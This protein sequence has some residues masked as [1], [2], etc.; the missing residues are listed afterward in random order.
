MT[1]TDEDLTGSVVLEVG[2]GRGGTTRTLV[3]AL[4]RHAG[5]RLIVTDVSDAHFQRLRE[6]FED[7]RVPIRFVRTQAQALEGIGRDTVDY[8]VCNYTLCAVNAEPGQAI[9]ALARFREVLREGG[10]LFVEEEFPIGLAE[11]SEQKIWAE[12]WRI[13]KTM[14]VAAGGAPYTEFAPDTLATLCALVGFREVGW[15]AA[16]DAYQGDGVLDFFERRVE[17]LLG[18]MPNESLQAG[19]A[20]WALALRETLKPIGGMEVPY[21][22]LTAQA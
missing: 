12:K 19:F 16:T 5:A 3:D 8:L 14:T 1:I 10:R 20:Q 9:L 21:Y 11:T 2:S 7:K 6:E 18:A 17:R 13:L 15:I 4:S 22:R